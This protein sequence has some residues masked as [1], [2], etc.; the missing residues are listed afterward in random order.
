MIIENNNI[1]LGDCLSLMPYMKDNSIDVIFADLPYGTTNCSWDTII[2][3][4]DYMLVDVGK[5]LSLCTKV[6]IFYII[7]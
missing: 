3:L 6:I 2:P 7:H 5:K 4:N 1:Y